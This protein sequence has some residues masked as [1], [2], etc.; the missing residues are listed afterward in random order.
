MGLDTE[1]AGVIAEM[2]C[3]TAKPVLYVA[4]AAEADLVPSTKSPALK[5]L[6]VYAE[7]EGVPL[8]PICAKIEAELN[9]LSVTD[10][11]EFLETMN[12]KE[13]G[14]APLSR[15]MY[16]LLGFETFFTFNEKELRAW[17][18]RA[19]STAPQ[20]AGT[21]HSDFEKGFVKADVYSVE[22]LEAYKSESAL[23]AAGKIRSEGKE[24]VV[25]DGEILFFKF[26]Q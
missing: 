8:I 3:I 18:L 24:Y 13:S 7:K 20:A 15:A 17:N 26:T 23:R 25:K 9:D 2:H 4:N 5:A 11:L 1:S 6:E 14:L 12:L 21:I 19:G 22:D 10:R 16:K